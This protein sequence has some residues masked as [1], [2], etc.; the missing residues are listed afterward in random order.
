[1]GH[2]VKY[3]TYAENV[4][5]KKVQAEWDHYAAMEDWKEGASSLVHPIRWIDHIC[6]NEEE[7]EEYIKEHDKGWYDQ[8]AVKFRDIP[9]GEPSKTLL[10]LK[11]RLKAVQEKRSAYVEAHSVRAFKAEYIGCPK[12]GSKLKRELLRGDWC[13][14]CR[15]ELLS[16][17]TIETLDRYSKN[18]CEL[19][20]QINAEEKK[21]QEKSIKKSTIKWLV[22]IEYHT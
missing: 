18:I 3:R 17:T 6:T 21:L 10:S 1:M 11:K 8:L 5:K 16:K 13:P 22:K 15:A 4:D 14:L 12:C 9:V 19:Y 2:N 7:A 20:K